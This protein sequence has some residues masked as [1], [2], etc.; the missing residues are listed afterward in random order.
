[1]FSQPWRSHQGKSQVVKSKVKVWFTVHIT[2]L[3]LYNWRSGEIFFFLAEWTGKAEIRKADIP[4]SKQS[5]QS[6]VLSKDWPM[7]HFKDRTFDSSHFSGKGTQHPTTGMETSC[8][9]QSSKHSETEKCTE[10][11]QEE[12]QNHFAMTLFHANFQESSTMC[13]P[14]LAHSNSFYRGTQTLR[15]LST[16]PR[17][18]LQLHWVLTDMCC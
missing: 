8:Y 14:T 13:T 16:S 2:C 4:G 10:I 7:Q 6:F 5:M 18:S 3:L 11:V 12:F 15:F 1:M 9:P 17:C